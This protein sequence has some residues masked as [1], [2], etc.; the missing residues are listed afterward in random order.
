MVDISG[1]AVTSRTAE[2]IGYIKVSGDVMRAVKSGSASKGD[3]LQV[4][5]IAGIT[6]VKKTSEL[7]PLTHN[8]TVD[9]CAVDF[10]ADESEGRIYAICRVSLDG[11]TGA[12]MEALTGVSA[13][14]LTIYDMCK[15]IDKG[16]EIG[17]IHLLRKTGGKS[18]EWR[19]PS[20]IEV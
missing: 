9:S 6:G 12:E 3:V 10:R 1:K 15:A 17:G 11:R 20:A 7:I 5:R 8:I 14:L 13:A 19:A 2:A 18:G 16:M 4:A